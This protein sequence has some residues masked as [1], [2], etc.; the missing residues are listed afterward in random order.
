MAVLAVWSVIKDA[1]SAVMSWLL[2]AFTDAWVRLRGGT[3]T[4]RRQA[5]E[6]FLTPLL[7]HLSEAGLGSISEIADGDPPHTPRGCPFQ[8][9]SMGELL[10]LKLLVLA[11]EKKVPRRKQA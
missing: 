6:R 2:G 9:W 7:R 1:G 11:E 5:R 4:A 3:V 8:A 10:R